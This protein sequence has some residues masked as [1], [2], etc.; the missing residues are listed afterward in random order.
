MEKILFV[1]AC[2]RPMSRTLELARHVL[3]KLDGEVEELDLE[4]EQLRPHTWE[5]LQRREKLL[6]A[7]DFSDPMFRCACQFRQAD[8]VVIAAPYYDLSFPS[9]LKNW[10]ESIC[11]VGLT[12]YYDE[13]EMP[14]TLC[15][16]KRLIYVTTS[17]AEF[18]PDFGY[19]YIRRV[20][21]EFFGVGDSVCF[22]AEKLDLRGT[23]ADALMAAAKEKIDTYFLKTGA[24]S[25]E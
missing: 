20:F 12:F 24:V 4:T 1:N 13:N 21:S 22:Y 18:I 3:D 17:G 7:G 2:I 19:G 25:A 16:G 15:K 10:I 9:S 14:Q 23:D 8:T 5:R 6:S 11:N